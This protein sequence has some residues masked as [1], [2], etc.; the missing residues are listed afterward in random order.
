MP[1]FEYNDLNIY[2]ED[3]G[4]GRA[5]ILLPGN[6]ASSAV[7]R[8]DIEYFSKKFRVICPDYIGYGKS[9]R[10][11]VLPSDFW[12]VNAVMVI[13][14]LKHL[15]EERYL[16]VGTSGGGVI[17]LN[18]AI[19]EPDRVL[20]IVVDSF[21]GEILDMDEIHHIVMSR[22][23][24]TKE[25][26]TFWCYAHGED[27]EKVVNQDSNML[28]AAAELQKNLNK[29]RLSEVKSPVLFTASLG[30]ELIPSVEEKITS[31][32]TK[33]PNWKIVLYS[34]GNHPLIWSRTA[35]FREEVEEF[36]KGLDNKGSIL[37]DL[38]SML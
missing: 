37:E 34:S 29:G 7:H 26:C 20:G 18:I 36:I 31:M 32:V 1:Y 12:W 15:K 27:W 6:T 21:A 13:E 17:G 24:K 3:E 22:K 10:V 19:Q 4:K 9:D 28:I 2:Y 5:L 35:E 38:S 25:Q 30:D 14:L 23:T 8:R 11:R 16:L 33:I